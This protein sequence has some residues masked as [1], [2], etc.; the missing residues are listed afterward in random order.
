MTH[1]MSGH[2][3]SVLDIFISQ[4]IFFFKHSFHRRQSP[5]FP[6]E[7]FHFSR[8]EAESATH[9]EIRGTKTLF[10]C[11]L[12]Q[13]DGTREL[14]R[15]V[16]SDRKG[17]SVGSWDFQMSC[18]W[19]TSVIVVMNYLAKALWRSGGSF[20]LQTKGTVFTEAEACGCLSYWI[21]G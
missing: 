8:D 18:M 2:K 7:H 6:I 10:C 14:E 9:S 5:V 1:K 15:E 16:V 19:V 12:L 20:G 4:L 13:W 3:L 11:P 21:W 17:L